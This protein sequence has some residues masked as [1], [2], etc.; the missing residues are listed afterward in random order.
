MNVD[1]LY[2]KLLKMDYSL[3]FNRN[4]FNIYQA[5]D[6]NFLISGIIKIKKDILIDHLKNNKS[7]ISNHKSILTIKNINKNNRYFK[8][9]LLSDYIDYPVIDFLEECNIY[10]NLKKKTFIYSFLKEIPLDIKD[11]QCLDYVKYLEFGYLLLVIKEINQHSK[12][13]IFIYTDNFDPILLPALMKNFT[14]ILME[15]KN[16]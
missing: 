13:E 14:T 10:N 5:D 9:K 4:N 16:I 7:L 6:N 15:L 8:I 2:K 11:K 1:E 3:L 12:I